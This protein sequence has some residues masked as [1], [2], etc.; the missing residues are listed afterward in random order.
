MTRKTSAAVGVRERARVRLLLR[1]SL[2]L[3][4]VVSLPVSHA[5]AA[6]DPE[7]SPLFQ[8]VLKKSIE[9][10]DHLPGYPRERD[11]VP[12][13]AAPA[14]TGI[15]LDCFH[16][17]LTI[18]FSLEPT[19][20]N[21]SQG[22]EVVLSGPCTIARDAPPYDDGEVIQTEIAGM[23]LVG[24]TP[25]GP[26]YVTKRWDQL[27]I[28][29]ITNVVTDGAGG[30]VQGESSFEAFVSVEFPDLELELNTSDIPLVWDAGLITALPPVGTPYFDAA[31]STPVQLR[32]ASTGNS[33]GWICITE[34]YPV[35]QLECDTLCHC[36]YELACAEGDGQAMYEA[37]VPCVGE[38]RASF[39]CASGPYAH[40]VVSF[41]ARAGG[42]C[43]VWNWTGRCE[44]TSLPM[45][46]GP[47]E[48]CNCEPDQ[49]TMPSAPTCPGNASCPSQVSC[50]DEP[51][52]P[53]QTSCPGY[54]SCP[55]TASCPATASC[56]STASCPNS[57]S[58]PG[59]TS[60]G[61]TASCPDY[62]SCSDNYT[63]PGEPTCP[64]VQSC[65][66][67]GSCDPD[68]TC[69]ATS[70]MRAATC[71]TSSTCPAFHTCP[72]T[73]TCGGAVSCGQQD[74]YP[75]AFSVDG[76]IN[77]AEGLLVPDHPEPNDVYAVGPA[78]GYVT[79]GEIFQ[80][81][82]AIDGWPPDVTNWD[83]MSSS[84]GIYG[85]VMGWPRYHGP[86]APNTG[87][88]V[89]QPPPPGGLGTFGLLPGDNIDALSYGDD[90][91]E[92]LLFSV[93]TF[94]QGAYG[95]AVYFEANVSPQAPPL[96]P[97]LPSNGGGDPGDEAAG[98]LF[99][100][101]LCWRFGGG[102]GNEL[103]PAPRGNNTLELDEVLLGL[104]APAVAWSTGLG[105]GE[106]DLDALETTDAGEVDYCHDGSPDLFSYFSL[107]VH[108]IQVISGTPDPFPGLCT[109]ADADGV[110]ADDILISLPPPP[111][112][113]RMFSYA[114]YA[115]GVQDIGLLS[116]DD[117][118]AMCLYDAPPVGELGPGD[119]ALFS[120]AQN[121]PSLS[122]GTN[123]NMPGP[124]PFSP[125]DVFYT[126][127]PGSSGPI[128]YYATTEMLGLLEHDEL[129]AIDIGVCLLCSDDTDRDDDGHYDLCD[130]C[131]DD[132]NA[133]QSD[134]DRDAVGDTCDNC[135][136][137]WNPDQT[138]TDGDGLGDVCDP[139]EPDSVHV[140]SMT[141]NTG[142]T[143][144]TIPIRLWNSV[145]LAS[146]SVPL[147]VRELTPGAYI[148]NLS[149]SFGDRLPEGTGNPLG[150]ISFMRQY[151][152]PDGSCKPGGFGTQ[153]T[154]DFISPDAVRF[155]RAK[156]ILAPPLSPGSD[157]TGSLLLTVDVTSTPG[158]FE[159]DTTCADPSWHLFYT[160]ESPGQLIVPAFTKGIITVETP[161]DP[162]SVTV[163]SKTV[164]TGRTAVQI[165]IL[166]E[167][168]VTIQAVTVPL[169]IR[170]V[171]PGSYITAL[172][173]SFGDRLPDPGQPLGDIID[174]R[175]YPTPNGVC[176]P[177]GFGA[178][179]TADFV[180][181]DG[182]VFT[183]IAFV[184]PHWLPP[185]TDV[186][187]SMILT[188]DVTSTLGTFEIDTTCTDPANR[189]V[190]IDEFGLPIVPSFVKGVITIGPSCACPYQ[191]DFDADGFV[192]SLDLAA[193]ID[194][195]FASAPD[196]QDPD[197]PATRSDLDCDGFATPLDL[198]AIIDHLF[199]SGSA[200]C[201]P[202]ECIPDYPDDCPPWP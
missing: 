182:V 41:T 186:T 98:D 19:D 24:T 122:A 47:F 110:T 61:E 187:G 51:T 176:K 127:F 74:E 173:L 91:G 121:S 153:A 197:C 112:G 142:A 2:V 116:G 152:T 67:S 145:S 66:G 34:L 13:P 189:F 155:E 170:E 104:Q 193:I 17:D 202:C 28:G 48:S 56:P 1:L 137:D 21:C 81:S 49:P 44:Q 123:P 10:L 134:R 113:P 168:V 200:P 33:A 143:G 161:P 164:A 188:V 84:L 171:T 165:P 151:P 80:S 160:P 192:T 79:Q 114:I 26:M 40:C 129:D 102:T 167:N 35:T 179:G 72:S 25:V 195:L 30:F 16:A 150:E 12:T 77:P 45:V 101:Q 163:T 18:Y 53:D 136:D 86:F 20:P 70:C 83:R 191:G 97:N 185:G 181:P 183:R 90:K 96:E 88:P 133:N 73:P 57:P 15:V 139:G 75:V 162:N 132:W 125:G 99:C 124:G 109:G 199:V 135:P 82:G 115:R 138:D 62:P 78:N 93:N 64:W 94:A 196:P 14:D 148:T 7:P 169:V 60:C 31:G 76:A 11:T 184:S 190:L 59:Y 154:A 172:S 194:I 159:I 29:S 111:I 131:P 117:I 52:C 120:L 108:S 68:P 201:D 103:H 128:H 27:S 43:Q 198:T 6:R 180:S 174:K 157:A 85:A 50:L 149:T 140:T 130:N 36:I 65:P 166:L 87:W 126:Q 37:G 22:Y 175:Q 144:V 9:G 42:G 39:V 32:E 105:I 63:C 3:V 54:V 69:T 4:L 146:V 58:C 71:A 141:V 100:S 119:E 106:D 38:E 107:D 147:V 23:D 156:I 95:T 5:Q 158:Q 177:G 92:V 55:G 89:P 118:D 46:P 8:D 178:S